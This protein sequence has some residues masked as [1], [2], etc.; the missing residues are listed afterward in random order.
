MELSE[1][2]KYLAENLKVEVESA[3]TGDLNNQLV[4]VRLKIDNCVISRS[5][6][7][8]LIK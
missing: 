3:H 8:V 6:C 1:I 4:A 2:I 5:D 7:E